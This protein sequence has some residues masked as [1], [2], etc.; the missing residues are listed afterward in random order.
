MTSITVS[1]QV[2]TNLLSS[3]TLMSKTEISIDE[4]VHVNKCKLMKT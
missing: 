3:K 4:T 2:F 1:Q